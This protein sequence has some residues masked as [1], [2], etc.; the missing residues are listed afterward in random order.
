MGD[1]GER[2]V[3]NLKKW[4][5]SF[6]DGPFIQHFISQ[7]ISP[8]INKLLISTEGFEYY[9]SP[10]QTKYNVEEEEAKMLAY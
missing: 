2:G 3:K 1:Q 5:M 7:T 9:F 10:D 6:M 8:I 4:V